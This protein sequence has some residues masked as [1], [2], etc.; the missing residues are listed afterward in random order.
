MTMNDIRALDPTNPN[1][2]ADPD[3]HYIVEVRPPKAGEAYLAGAKIFFADHD[4]R[5]VKQVVI[6]GVA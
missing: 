6:V 1:N 2:W 3:T 4:A 5:F